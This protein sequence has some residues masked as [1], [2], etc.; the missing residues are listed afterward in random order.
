MVIGPA[1]PGQASGGP[2][3]TDRTFGRFLT[4]TSNPAAERPVKS[5]TRGAAAGPK[6]EIGGDA[7][8]VSARCHAGDMAEK[9]L[10]SRLTAITLGARDLPTLRSFYLRLGWS[11]LPNSGDEWT[12]F[13]LGGVLLTLYPFE[14]LAQEAAPGATP[15]VGWNGITLACNV[16]SKEEVDSAYAAALAAGAI[17]VAEPTDR[18]WGG[19]SGY[20]ADPEGN[21]WEIAWADGTNFDERGAL[22]S[23]G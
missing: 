17:P 1:H 20:I 6:S 5:T 22:V 3:A 13:L 9:T 4:G 14:A 8:S 16:D 19:R 21:R 2:P 10:P 11:E 18:F 23:F 15:Q 12:A 7:K